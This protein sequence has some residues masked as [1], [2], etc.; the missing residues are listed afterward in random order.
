MSRVAEKASNDNGDWEEAAARCVRAMLQ[1]R[2]PGLD[3]AG[4]EKLAFEFGKRGVAQGAHARA[5]D[6][7]RRGR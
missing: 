2:A 3:F 6:A 4:R 5:P 1:N 7:G